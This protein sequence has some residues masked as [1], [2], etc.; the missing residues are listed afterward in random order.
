MAFNRI[1]AVLVLLIMLGAWGGWRRGFILA[2]LLLLRG[3]GSLLAGWLWFEPVAG[4]LGESTGLPEVWRPPVAFVLIVLLA[5][6][7]TAW[8]GHALLRRLPKAIHGRLANRL[9]GLFPGLAKGLILAVLAATLAWVAP[10]PASWLQEAR[11]SALGQ[12]LVALAEP[13]N[14]AL[15]PIF[16]E[17]LANA[18]ARLVPADS[19]PTGRT[20][21]P[22]KV[23][24]PEPRP[25]LEAEM[26]EL[27]NR[28]RA[29]A[30][31]APLRNDPALTEVARKHSADMLTR[32]YFSHDTPEHK[33]PFDR[34][35]E[36]KLSFLT[37]GENLALAPS[38]R[39]AHNGLMNSPGHRRNILNPRFRRIGIGI[40][41]GG[42]HGLMVTQS[43]RN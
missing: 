32:R 3:L 17:A 23:E 2:A 24:A 36:A 21:L 20:A 15:M 22:F 37:A 34:M 30:G 4:W 41:D 10:L 16:E 40:M 6:L 7:L 35:R 13:L 12:R 42:K 8:L 29:A 25:A 11:A 14:A 28:E 38:V 19:E 26:L 33:S 9:L 18:S 5:G 1:D 39:V 31:V 43:F 27:V